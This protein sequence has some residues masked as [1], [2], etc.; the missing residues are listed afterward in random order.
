MD[1]PFS[2]FVGRFACVLH[3]LNS[4]NKSILYYIIPSKLIWQVRKQECR[5]S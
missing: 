2:S 1:I 5:E 4:Q 3:S